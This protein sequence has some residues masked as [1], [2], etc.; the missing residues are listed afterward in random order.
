MYR[1]DKGTLRTYCPDGAVAFTWVDENN[2]CTARTVRRYEVNQYLRTEDGKYWL[3][4]GYRVAWDGNF[5][6]LVPGVEFCK[7]TCTSTLHNVVKWRDRQFRIEMLEET[8]VYHFNQLR[9]WA[10]SDL[11]GEEYEVKHIS[12]LSNIRFFLMHPKVYEA[13]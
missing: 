7:S 5:W 3:A 4:K 8:E 2:Q 10:T 13:A 9:V 12:T 11:T 6:R 1:K